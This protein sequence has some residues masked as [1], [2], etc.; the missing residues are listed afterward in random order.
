MA[1]LSPLRA[2]FPLVPGLPLVHRGKVRDTY[3]INEQHLLVVC[4]DGISVFDFVLNATIIEKGMILNAL[5]HFWLMRLQDVGI[6]SHFVAAGEA[7]DEFLP[8]HLRGSVDLQSRAMVVSA[9]TMIPHEFI[10]RNALTGSVLKEYNETSRIYGQQ[11]PRGLQDGDLLPFMLDT[12]T[13]KEEV[14]HDIPSDR[15]VIQQKYPEATLLLYRIVQLVERESY[16]HG[17][18]LADTKLEFGYDANGRL[19]VG[20]EVGTPDSSRFWNLDEWK[21][22]RD[23]LERAAPQPHDKQ[24]VRYWGMSVGLNDSARFDPK[25]EADVKKVHKIEVP[26]EVISAT[27]RIYRDLFEQVTHLTLR[28]YQSSKLGIR[29]NY[30]Q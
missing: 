19:T 15:L 12:P 24:R 7:I 30:R 29:H 6:H 28:G 9:L 8:A 2:A 25:S 23:K 27:S 17:L 13:T 5:N 26:W 18:V 10:G 22:S 3:R 21:R 20:D 4:S 1:F 16:R 14:G 11:L